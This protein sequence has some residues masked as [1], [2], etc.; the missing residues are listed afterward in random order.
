MYRSTLLDC[1]AGRKTVGTITGVVF[2][3][4]VKHNASLNNMNCAYVTQDNYHIAVLTVVETLLFAAQLRMP[5]S[6]GEI[7][8]A[9]RVFQI[10]H[11]LELTDHKDT[12]VGDR[13]ISSGL[14]GGQLKRLSI[15]VE[16]INLPELIF[17]D[18]VLIFLTLFLIL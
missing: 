9:N 14:S 12:K 1:L 11:M 5:E 17:L 3:N 6:V 16:M 2:I 13:E 4:K 7:A 18:E 10:M 15:G 8:K